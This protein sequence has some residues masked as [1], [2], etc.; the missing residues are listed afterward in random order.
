MCNCISDIK[1]IYTYRMCML[2]T[3]QRVH[4][5]DGRFKVKKFQ[6]IFIDIR[7]IDTYFT[8]SFFQS[9]FSESNKFCVGFKKWKVVMS[10]LAQATKFKYFFFPVLLTAN[11]L[12]WFFKFLASIYYSIS[13]AWSWNVFFFLSE[14]QIEF[15]NCQIDV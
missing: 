9:S 11:C 6:F 1:I 7:F 13:I 10:G 14:I 4:I 8:I 12:I 15:C 2:F 5:K 3:E